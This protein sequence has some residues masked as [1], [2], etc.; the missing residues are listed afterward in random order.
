MNQWIELP[1]KKYVI[2]GSY[3]LGTRYAKD[4]DVVCMEEDI[5]CEWERKDDYSGHF[6]FNGRRIEV[7]LADKQFS[8]QELLS[9]Y[10]RS[11]YASCDELYALKRGSIMYQNKFFDKHMGDLH[12][13]KES[14]TQNDWE[15]VQYRQLVK[16]HKKSTEERIGKKKTPKLI[17]RDKDDFFDD[18][19]KKHYVHDHIHYSVAHKEKP[20]YE[21][22]Q[23][24]TTKVE[25]SKDLWNRFS[26]Q[27]KVWTVDEEATV[28]AL[29][30]KIIPIIKGESVEDVNLFN[31]YKW[32]L[33]RIC[34]NLTSGWFRDFAIDNYFEILNQWRPNYLEIFDKNIGKY[35]A[36]VV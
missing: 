36:L 27:E 1:I 20:M 12:S 13:L 26:H 31:A 7:L 9:G 8:L 33:M 18:L 5:E 34:T 32:A 23:T 11:C 4:I 35:E 30:R 15:N 16:T 22:M 19:V 21:Y 17:G 29:E 3:A 14:L 25:C 24:D 10:S 2:V 28:I 6:D